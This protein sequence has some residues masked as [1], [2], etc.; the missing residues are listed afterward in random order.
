VFSVDYEVSYTEFTIFTKGFINVF[1]PNNYIACIIKYTVK[2]S[3]K[4]I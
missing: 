3:L 4:I 1:I 2:R